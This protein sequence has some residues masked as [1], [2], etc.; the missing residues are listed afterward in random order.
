M[1]VK[2][3]PVVRIAQRILSWVR[4]LLFSRLE[5]YIRFILII[6]VSRLLPHQEITMSRRVLLNQFF[7]YFQFHVLTSIS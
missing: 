3:N 2:R 4:F 5:K 1:K 6:P 7:H